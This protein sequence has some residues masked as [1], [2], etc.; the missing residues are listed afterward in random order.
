MFVM[1]MMKDIYD[2]VCC[3]ETYFL[4]WVLGHSSSSD[5]SSVIIHGH[6]LDDKNGSLIQ[7]HTVH[8]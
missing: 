8:T 7:K 5:P 2:K 6:V 1:L 3:V 4:N